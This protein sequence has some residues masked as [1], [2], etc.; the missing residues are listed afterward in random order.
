MVVDKGLADDIVKGMR[1][2]FF[3][4]DYIGG[5]VLVAS[6]VV[7]KINAE[8]SIVKVTNRFNMSKDLKEGLVGRASLK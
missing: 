8:T 1:I 3:E 7:I 2:D 5:N 4:F 6:G